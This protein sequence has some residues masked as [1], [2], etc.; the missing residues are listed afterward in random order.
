GIGTT[1]PSYRLDVAGDIRGQNNL[2]VSGNVGIGTITPTT[3]KLQ[4]ANELGNK[5]VVW[6]GGTSDRYG[7][8]L[9]SG[10]LNVFIP[11]GARFSIRNN[12]Y[13]G[14][15]QFVV[16]GLGNVGIGTTSPSYRL[17]VA[18]DIRGQNNLYVS[19]SVGIGTTS[20]SQKLD[21]QGGNIKTSGGIY[22][23]NGKSVLSTDQGGSIELGDGLT[24]G[25]APYI[26]FHYGVGSAQDYNVRIQN[27][28]DGRLKLA[29]STVYITG[30]VGIG[31]PTPAVS[32][33]VMGN[34]GIGRTDV[35]NA[36]GWARTLTL[37]GGPHAKLLVTET[38]AGVKTGIFSHSN[39]NGV[40]GRI[41]TESSHDLRLMAG[42][43]NDVV[44]ITTSGNVG[45]GTTNPQGKL[46]VENGKIEVTDHGAT[47]DGY[48]AIS[49]TNP[50]D[51]NTYSYFSLTRQGN[52]V[53]GIGID[54]SNKFVIGVQ[55]PGDKTNRIISS[56]RLAMDMYGNVGIGT[57]SPSSKL[58]VYGGDIEINDGAATGTYKIKGD[59]TFY[60]GDET[61][62]STTSTTDE[63][64][65]QL[66]MVFD[67]NYGIKP[68]YVNIIARIR[69]SGGYTTTLNVTIEGCG[70]ILLTTTS[71][72]YTLVKGTISTSNCGDGIYPTKIYLKT[73]NSAGTAYNDL[74][75]FYYVK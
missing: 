63:L 14:T 55:S 49:V 18:G 34:V 26:D 54:P 57:T 65:K 13:D 16:T 52:M 28:A 75:E 7:I 3:G 23:N 68:N 37:T 53:F 51:S 44:T 32:L 10:N 72:S 38:T 73:S 17:D 62:V 36:Q 35:D 59:R 21:V 1:S 50:A 39:W 9:N 67:S 64:K 30:N 70:G 41:G 12:G 43:G 46:H 74:I 25:Q 8:G 61:E 60:A 27:D 19:G 58:E 5:I 56:V 2:Y 42:Y 11:T 22:W 33:A 40:V 31:T 48:G 24:I 6:D 4:F 66:T 69:N 47:A 29:A 15:E 20:P 71:T 45:I